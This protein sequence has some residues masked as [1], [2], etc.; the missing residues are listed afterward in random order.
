MTLGLL[1]VWLKELLTLDPND[2]SFVDVHLTL[3]E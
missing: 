2:S 3:V 1:N